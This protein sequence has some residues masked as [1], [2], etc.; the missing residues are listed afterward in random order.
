MGSI[1][2]INSFLSS[3]EY[4]MGS[5]DTIRTF[6]HNPLTWVVHP[7]SSLVNKYKCHLIMNLSFEVI[8]CHDRESRLFGPR[9]IHHPFC[10]DHHRIITLLHEN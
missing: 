3:L 8:T 1:I 10:K 5:S 9:N 7:R 2:Q 4:F 6:E